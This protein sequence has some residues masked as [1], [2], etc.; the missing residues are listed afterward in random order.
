MMRSGN[1][2]SSHSGLIPSE[3]LY[4][5]RVAML[6]QIA[7]RRSLISLRSAAFSTISVSN[8]ARAYKFYGFLK[9]PRIM[10]LKTPQSRDNHQ[11]TSPLSFKDKNVLINTYIIHNIK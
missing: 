11:F 2:V 7:R 5:K 10:F 6:W 9:I 3:T 8:L 1:A 4:E